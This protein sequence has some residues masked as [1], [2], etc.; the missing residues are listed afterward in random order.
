MN[1]R[2][3]RFLTLT[4][5]LIAIIIMSGF[6]SNAKAKHLGQQAEQQR[7]HEG[8][9]QSFSIQPHP[10][11][12]NDPKDLDRQGPIGAGYGPDSANMNYGPGPVMPDAQ[13][14]Q[15]M[16]PVSSRDQLK[17]RSA[18]LNSH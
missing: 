3:L 16:P 17:A 7:A 18:A 14:Q 5:T 13:A 12:T 2:I 8:Q 15:N 10:A 9:E 1:R 4:L 6:I 11:K